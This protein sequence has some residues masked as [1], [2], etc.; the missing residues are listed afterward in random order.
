MKK[1][2]IADIIFILLV[3]LVAFAAW[4]MAVYS[5]EYANPEYF[6]AL[7]ILP[8]WSIWFVLKEEK[9]QPEVQLST[10]ELL[11]SKKINWLGFFR[12]GL[13]GLRLL[14]LA[15]VIF[16]L[17]R[18]Q[19]RD[20]WQDATAEGIDVMIALDISASMLAKDFSPN[21][22][23]ASKDVAI[24]FID[25]RRTDRIGL[26]VYEGES[27]TQ[28]P[29][30]SD[31]KVLKQLFKD[32]KTGLIEGGTAI[33]MGLAT[34][35]NR[36][37]ESE[38]KSKVIILLTDGVNNKG[39]IAPITAA[40]IAKE[41]GIRVY[42]IGVGSTGMALSPVRMYPNGQYQ[43]DKVKVEIDELTL[44]KIAFQTGGKYFRAENKSALKDIYEQIDKLEKTK[45]KVTEYS[46][47][48]EEFFVFALWAGMLLLFEVLLKTTLFRSI[49]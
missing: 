13:F 42:T 43:Y 49:P 20:S 5:F 26:V 39:A 38:A 29:L 31:H 1:F 14:A 15:C 8:L 34:A 12:P 6:W 24:Q 9:M 7:L 25:Q 11:R 41:F 2:K 22:L 27:Y 17:A 21:R 48:T 28:C 3:N 40:E 44:E 37:R 30:T 19:S 32:V 16:A 33:G 18:P 10:F 35:V 45:I 46:Q 4:R 47:K 36:L 23:E